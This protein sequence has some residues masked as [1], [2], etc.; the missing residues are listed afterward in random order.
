MPEGKLVATPTGPTL[1]DLVEE[2][3][4]SLAV[5]YSTHTVRAYG[6]ALE[7]FLRYLRPLQVTEAR[8]LTRRHVEGWQDQLVVRRLSQGT[9]GAYVTGLRVFVKW[10]EHRYRPFADSNLWLD[11]NVVPHPERYVHP[12]ADAD[13]EK[14]LNHLRGLRPTLMNLRDRALVLTFLASG[15]RVNDILR[16][17]RKDINTLGEPVQRK[18]GGRSIAVPPSVHRAVQDYLAARTDDSPAMWIVVRPQ[19]GKITPLR[20]AGVLKIWERMAARIGVSRFTNEQL[21]HTA[22]L[23]MIEADVPYAAIAEHIGNKRIEPFRRYAAFLAKR[24]QMALDA[25]DDLLRGDK[26]KD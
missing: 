4:R 21:R 8:S 15:G 18:G 12:L 2:W 7:D 20:D 11:I 16:L 19:D 26:I 5:K 14:I 22:I 13:L 1:K 9:R 6:V 24:R 25:M 10:A 17:K 23:K 3:K